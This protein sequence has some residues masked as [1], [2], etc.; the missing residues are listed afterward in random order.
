MHTRVD[1]IVE[2]HWETRLPAPKPTILL[3]HIILIL[4]VASPCPI[5]ITS[6]VS[7]ITVGTLVVLIV[8][9]HWETMTEFPTQSRYLNLA[10]S[11]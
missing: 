2:P 10:L 1:I 7:H 3:N 6:K 4:A 5:L 8:L 9:P 11:Y